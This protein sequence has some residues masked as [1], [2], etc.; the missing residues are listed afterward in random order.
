MTIVMLCLFPADRIV[1]LYGVKIP[2]KNKTKALPRVLCICYIR[3]DRTQC[4]Q[5]IPRLALKRLSLEITI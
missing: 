5:I 2:Y 1:L 3:D 4:I